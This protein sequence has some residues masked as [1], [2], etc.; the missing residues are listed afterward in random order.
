[1]KLQRFVA[2]NHKQDE[3]AVFLSLP[4]TLSRQSYRARPCVVMG[5]KAVFLDFD[6]KLCATSEHDVPAFEAATAA[7]AATLVERWGDTAGPI[8]RERLRVEYKFMMSASH[9]TRVRTR[10]S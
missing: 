9:G 6:D 3:T 4:S 1:M 2:Y 8:D 10:W 7:A 5:L